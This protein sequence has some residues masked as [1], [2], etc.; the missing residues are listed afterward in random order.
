MGGP[1][2]AFK[3]YNSR[4]GVLSLV[5]LMRLEILRIREVLEN[6]AAKSV[7]SLASMTSLKGI[8]WWNFL[9]WVRSLRGIRQMGQL[10]AGLTEFLFRL[11]DYKSGLWANNISY[12]GRSQ[13]ILQS[14][15]NQW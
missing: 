14:W 12:R 1:I 15:L 10:K 3:R 5:I 6:V 8:F 2:S 4:S 11:S 7:R 13:I 9:S